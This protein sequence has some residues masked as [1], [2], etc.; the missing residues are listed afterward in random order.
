MQ[1]MASGCPEALMCT[2]RSESILELAAEAKEAAQ[3]REES[4]SD[5]ESDSDVDSVTL[6]TLNR[7]NNLV[8]IMDEIMDGSLDP[9]EIDRPASVAAESLADWETEVLINLNTAAG[10]SSDAKSTA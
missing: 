9:N 5:S 2:M 6:S 3:V 4:E 1:R 8:E 10:T 7:M